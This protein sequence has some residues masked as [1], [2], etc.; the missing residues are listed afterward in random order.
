MPDHAW[1]PKQSHVATL[2]ADH[3]PADLWQA[4]A[5]SAPTGFRN[6]AKMAVAGTS[7]HPTL[8]I[9]DGAGC[10]VDLRTCPLHVPAVEA[11]LP[12][13]ADL[14]TELAC[15]PTTYPRAAASSSTSW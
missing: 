2:L 12:V 1:P 7:G 3:V 6:K 4:P 5:A 15:A 10:G 8:G 9:L 13:L 11:A 14:I